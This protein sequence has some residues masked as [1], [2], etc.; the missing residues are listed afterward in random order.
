MISICTPTYDI[1]GRLISRTGYAVAQNISRRAQ[2]V[3]V[4]D[5]AVGA[6]PVDGGYSPADLTYTVIIPGDDGSAHAALKYMIANYQYVI[7]S[8]SDGCYR[9]LLSGLGN[10]NGQTTCTAEVLEDLT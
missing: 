8:C 1:D 9:V 2:R 5:L 10:N 7:L 4:L 6:V 3:A